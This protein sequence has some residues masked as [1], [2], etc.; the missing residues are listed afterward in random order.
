MQEARYQDGQI[1]A[2][3]GPNL[4][5]SGFPPSVAMEG[6]VGLALKDGG[7]AL[8]FD[9]NARQKWTAMPKRDF[10]FTVRFSPEK[11]RGVQGLAACAFQPREGFTGW[12]LLI[13]DGKP[14]LKIGKAGVALS[15]TIT[16][17]QPLSQGTVHRIDV[18]YDG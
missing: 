8:V 9:W 16:A 7:D 15:P 2:A 14:E 6:R 3:T 12:H 1:V 10:T 4:M 18:S 13:R 11:N 5:V 17:F